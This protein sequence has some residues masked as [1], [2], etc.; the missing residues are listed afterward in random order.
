MRERCWWLG[1]EIHQIRNESQFKKS[2]SAGSYY[3]K[4]L[5]CISLTRLKRSKF[6]KPKNVKKLVSKVLKW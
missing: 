6:A 4:A 5:F 3:K 2:Q 1:E